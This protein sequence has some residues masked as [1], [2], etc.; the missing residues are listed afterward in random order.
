MTDEQLRDLSR[1]RESSVF[2]AR[3]KLVLDLAVAMTRTPPDVS[4]EL[5]AQLQKH[6]TSAQLVELVTEIGLANLRGRF[7]TTFRCRVGGIF[8]G[9]VLSAARGVARQG[10]S[11][12]TAAAIIFGAPPLRD[13]ASMR[14]PGSER[15]RQRL[16]GDEAWRMFERAPA[17]VFGQSWTRVPSKK[18]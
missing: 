4:D 18:S 13:A 16:R 14:G 3:E 1:Y 11:P 5:F 17:R 6:F 12:E 2:T 9:R 10:L 7:N 8:R 15:E